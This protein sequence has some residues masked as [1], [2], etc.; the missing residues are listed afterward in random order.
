MALTGFNPGV[1]DSTLNNLHTSYE[2]L[3]F[4]ISDEVQS[5][6]IGGMSDK[7]AGNEAMNY[8]KNYFEPNNTQL[9]SLTNKNFTDL[10]NR[11]VS[12]AERWAQRTMTQYSH[13]R[14]QPMSKK[15]DVSVI[16]ENINGVRGIDMQASPSVLA[17]L[18]AIGEEAKSKLE[19]AKNILSSGQ[20]F[21]DN[22]GEQTSSLIELITLIKNAVQKFTEEVINE[23]DNAISKTIEAYGQD[24]NF[25]KSTLGGN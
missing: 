5:K 21:L 17:T 22:N 9:I 2:H 13:S 16:L 19:N 4:I 20:E 1:V 25:N 11:I 8:F 10:Y 6:F 18:K 23:A 3:M 14:F 15:V 7:W 12:A 24:V